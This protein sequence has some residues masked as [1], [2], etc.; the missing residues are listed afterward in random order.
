MNKQ[1]LI[2]DDEKPLTRAL[3]LKLLHEGFDAKSV[4]DGYEAIEVLKTGN[5]DLVLLD[6]MMPQKDGFK[7]LEEIKK[8]NIKTIVIV[9]SNLSQK[10]DIARA[11]ALGAVDY[12]VKADT[13]LADIVDKIKNHLV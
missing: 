12:F 10:E 7:V 5:F 6:L 2:V 13:S 9:S 4:Y 8:L 3:E 1:V 11:A